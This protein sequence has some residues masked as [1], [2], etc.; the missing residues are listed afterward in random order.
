M[1]SV[2]TIKNTIQTADMVCN[3]YLDDLTDADLMKRPHPKCNH[4]NWQVGHLIAS[5]N[6]MANGCFPG[7]LPALPEGFEE[8]YSKETTGNDDASAF[9][10]KAELME[11]FKKQRELVV[12]KLDQLSESDL[13]KPAPE[14][15]QAYAPNVG[16]ALNMLGSHW[17]MHAGQWVIVR[18]ELGREIVI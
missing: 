12:S 15:M 3:A 2:E 10:T 9:H 1:N 6:M 18:R 8:K 4:L 17:L 14:S 5:D 13:D 11:I 16:A 7:T